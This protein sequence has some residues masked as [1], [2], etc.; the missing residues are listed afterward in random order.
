[1]NAYD[2]AHRLAKSIKES[3]EY[4]EYLEKQKKAFLNE[5]NK[6]MIEDLRQR[7]FE[8]QMEQLSGNEVSEEKVEK[9]QKLQ[10]VLML[11]PDIKDYFMAEMRFSQLIADIYDIIEEAVN[12]DIE[13]K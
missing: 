7:A 2:E 10:D 8:I 11:N 13:E 6:E 9:V 5:K 12:V 1:M 4:K 3:D